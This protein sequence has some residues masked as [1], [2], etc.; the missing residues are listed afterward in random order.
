MSSR[1]LSEIHHCSENS[2]HQVGGFV[3]GMGEGKPPL[4][5]GVPSNQLG[6]LIRVW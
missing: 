3:L 1:N 5:M 2:L 6:D 4:V